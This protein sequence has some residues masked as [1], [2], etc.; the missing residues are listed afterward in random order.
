VQLSNQAA[1][2]AAAAMPNLDLL[3]HLDAAPQSDNHNIRSFRT[4]KWPIQPHFGF[5]YFE[6]SF[7]PLNCFHRQGKKE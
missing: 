4:I 3:H 1:E 6:R 7:G 5:I 2:F